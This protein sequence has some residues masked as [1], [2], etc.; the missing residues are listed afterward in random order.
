MKCS[1]LVGGQVNHKHRENCW[2]AHGN[3]SIFLF[4]HSKLR[5]FLLSPCV[6][7]I[8]KFKLTSKFDFILNLKYQFCPSPWT[9]LVR[10]FL[11]TKE[12]C[13][14]SKSC[15]RSSCFRFLVLGYSCVPLQ[16][17][18]FPLSWFL[19]GPLLV[20]CNLAFITFIFS[21]YPKKKNS[22]SFL[23]IIASLK[24]GIRKN[25]DE[26]ADVIRTPWS[27]AVEIWEKK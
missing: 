8:W 4:P 22:N 9:S 12:N 10:W 13:H 6:D 20:S 2:C 21:P 3:I 19:V 18:N 17:Y 1:S 16:L 5:L 15:L 26:V 7:K 14:Y 23:K 11:L 27:W 25:G 24:A